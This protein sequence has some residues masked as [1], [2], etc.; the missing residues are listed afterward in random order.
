MDIQS[1]THVVTQLLLLDVP[2]CRLKKA[3][4][5][6]FLWKFGV[7][8]EKRNTLEEH[9]KEKP[10]VSLS[11]IA[12]IIALKNSIII[13]Y[14]EIFL[15]I[16][17]SWKLKLIPL[18]FAQKFIFFPSLITKFVC[19]LSVLCSEGFVFGNKHTRQVPSLIKIILGSEIKTEFILSGMIHCNYTLVYSVSWFLESFEYVTDYHY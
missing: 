5:V 18:S 3:L 1:I 11:W 10:I 19:P 6:S 16:N 7:T 13:P 2:N 12:D 17:I 14:L 8:W 15:L 9:W 4:S